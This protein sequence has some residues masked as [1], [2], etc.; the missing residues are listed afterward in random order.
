MQFAS[1]HQDIPLQ[2]EDL[3]G[4]LLSLLA[5]AIHKAFSSSVPPVALCK[6]LS[7]QY[8][9]LLGSFVSSTKQNN[10]RSPIMQIV[11]AITRPKINFQFH[12][13]LTHR[14]RITEIPSL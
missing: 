7:F 5:H 11:D 8:I 12:D 4:I 3:C 10:K 13:A 14:S 2:G 1:K 9:L 6:F